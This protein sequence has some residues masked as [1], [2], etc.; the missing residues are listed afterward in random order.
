M[1]LFSTGGRDPGSAES[2]L[3]KV[4]PKITHLSVP[5][6]GVEVAHILSANTKSILVRAQD[7]TATIKFAYVA[8]ESST[9]FITINPR[10]VYSEDSLL[11]AS[12]TLFLQTDKAGQ[13]LEILEWS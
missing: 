4:T 7:K 5:T 12:T 13:T 8:T 1:A 3:T 6:A 9:K 2:G 11:L 10:A